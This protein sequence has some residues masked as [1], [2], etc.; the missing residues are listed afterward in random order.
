MRDVNDR[1]TGWTKTCFFPA[2]DFDRKGWQE[3]ARAF[4]ETCRAAGIPAVL[5]RSRSGRSGDIW[6]FSE[7][8]C[9]ALTRG[10]L[11]SAAG[12]AAAGETQSP[13]LIAKS[14]SSTRL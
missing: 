10:V 11:V 3:D 2:V 7:E 6:L 1:A 5:E 4:L 14:T 12:A 13:R 8:T 9:Y